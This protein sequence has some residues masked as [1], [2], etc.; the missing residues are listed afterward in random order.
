MEVLLENQFT[1]TKEDA[2]EISKITTQRY[3]IFSLLIIVVYIVS[4]IF[5]LSVFGFDWFWV[6][7]GV[8]VSLACLTMRAVNL[9]LA[10]TRF[11]QQQLV[12]HNHQSIIKTVTVFEECMESQSAN[13][14]QLTIF[15][16]RITSAK[17]TAHFM[18][19][20][21]EKKVI[22]PIKLSGFTKGTPEEFEAFL[23]E[24][25]IKVKQK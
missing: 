11:Y 8:V 13:G 1:L 24:K 21:Y 18:M 23:L 2:M 20:F 17:K 14:A 25:G 10:G 19:V 16:D 5:C 4:M 15:Y 3:R 9:R 12:L 6:T 22:V 7:V